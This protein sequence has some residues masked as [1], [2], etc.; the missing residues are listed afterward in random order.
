MLLALSPVFV[1]QSGTY[2]PYVFQLALGLGAVVLLLRGVRRGSTVDT[3]A[4]GVIMGIAAPAAPD[5][6]PAGTLRVP[7][8]PGTGVLAVGLQERPVTTD[9][10]VRRWEQRIAYRVTGGGTRVELL[11]PGQA[12]SS[13]A[14]PG[15]GWRVDVT[16]DVVRVQ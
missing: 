10:S 9:G 6:L 12:W 11:R 8:V 14:T 7:S 1:L 2:L 4:S 5:P 15:S 16:G 3:V 13:N